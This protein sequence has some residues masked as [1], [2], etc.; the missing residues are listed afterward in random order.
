MSNL[1]LYCKS[2]RQDLHRAHVLATSVAQF[3]EDHLPFYM[4]VPAE[5]MALFRA[6]L[7][8]LPVELL[9]DREI[10]ATDSRIDEKKVAALPGGRAQQIV[11]AQFWRLR[12]G[13]NYLCLDSD[14][15]FLRSFSVNDFLA[16]DA[17]P[18][19]I[20]HECKELLQFAATHGL[21]KVPRHYAEERH[22]IMGIF[23]RA[24]RAY[25]FGPA[26]LIWS[27]AVWRTL[28]EQYLSPRGMSFYDA[29]ELFPSEILWYGETLLKYRPIPLWPIEPL[30]RCFHYRAQFRAASRE[31]ES[32]RTIAQDYLGVVYQS[33]WHR[34][35][36]FESRWAR[37]WRRWQVV[38]GG[39]RR[40]GPLAE[41]KD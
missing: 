2:Y 34:Q 18:Y 6:R 13:E 27:A 15:K 39:R 11:K 29:I 26:P 32:E 12:L 31:G 22:K 5:D 24:G 37:R 28:D 9:D 4:S 8:G 40:R 3:N 7:S 33:N 35:M 38:I 17:H 21:S 14:C 23:G 25:D 36:D 19:T 16:P 10:I 30:F 41:S 1:V 20:I